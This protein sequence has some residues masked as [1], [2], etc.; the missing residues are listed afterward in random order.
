MD[1]RME[2]SSLV[3]VK[4][5]LELLRWLVNPNTIK[6]RTKASDFFPPKE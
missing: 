1:N 4:D 2:E 6:R 5:G 3:E